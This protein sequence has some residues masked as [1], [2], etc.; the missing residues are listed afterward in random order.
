MKDD[1]LISKIF[2]FICLVSIAVIG[3]LIL[4]PYLNI[5]MLSVVIATVTFPFYRFFKRILKNKSI[6][7]LITSLLIIFIIVLPIFFVIFLVV[8]EAID[9]YYKIS[10][11]LKSEDISKYLDP[12][13]WEGVIEFLKEN[14]PFIKIEDLNLKQ[15]ITNLM[16]NITTTLVN[17]STFILRNLTN[18]L[19][20]LF[21]MFFTMFFLYRDGNRILERLKHL[22]PLSTT[23]E[24]MVINKFKVISYSIFFGMFVTAIAQGVI[25]GIGF[26]IIGVSPLFMGIMCAAFSIVPILGTSVV[27]LPVSLILLLT[28]NYWE[29]IFIALWCFGIGFIIENYGRP[30]LIKGKSNLHQLLVF[31][32]ILG[33]I[34]FFG[35]LGVIFGPVFAALAIILMD[36]YSAEYK[37]T[38]EKLDDN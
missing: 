32:S 12:K 4:E 8:N 24:E 14:A 10:I 28:G 20:Y 16:G 11:E 19:W 9:L 6:A 13:N 31:F 37:T 21:L 26:M 2:L 22:S 34:H 27:W 36:I 38:L 18:F 23:Y 15:E 33:G 25:C 17:S 5:I 3:Y 29:A 1:H 7:S 30:L 35:V